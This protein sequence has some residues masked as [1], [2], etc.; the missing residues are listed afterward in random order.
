MEE[1][2]VETKKNP[3]A[4][5]FKVA[6]GYSVYFLALM[7]LMKWVGVDQ[8]SPDT[9]SVEKIIYSIASYV[10]FIMTVV[11]VQSTYKKELGGFISF[12]KA[13]SSG[14]KV[15]A[16]T[17]LFVAVLSILYYKVLDPQAFNE[18][19][20]KAAETAGDDPDKIKGV[21]MMKPYM[22]FFIGFGV[23]VSYTIYGLIISLV[24]AAIVKKD[25]PQYGDD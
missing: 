21:N 17:G 24:G 5:A 20:D 6:L 7:Y 10:P 9:N 11:F 22:A 3:N 25:V 19:L 12:G 15:A 13:F 1:Q 14:F 8:N 18:I 4:L 23:A 16:Y 2:L